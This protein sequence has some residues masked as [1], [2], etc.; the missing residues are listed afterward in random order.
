MERC[1]E[2][3]HTQTKMLSQ[4]S[5][6]VQ[7]GCLLVTAWQDTTA[8]V[9]GIAEHNGHAIVL[10]T[11]H[12]NSH[13][14]QWAEGLVWEAHNS[15]SPGAAQQQ[16]ERSPQL[17]PARSWPISQRPLTT[18][19]AACPPA[20]VWHPAAGQAAD[21]HH[22]PRPACNGDAGCCAWTGLVPLH[23]E[24]HH[25]QHGRSA[26]QTGWTFRAKCA[27]PSCQARGRA[28]CIYSTRG[29]GGP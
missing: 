29:P 22:V 6:G 20:A 14:C 26:M 5:A 11:N 24:T 18:T 27:T 25:I 9:A 21:M 15:C 28:F 1:L 17:C 23:D 19:P 7:V 2:L 3:M 16:L 12:L 4:T 13:E 8:L 10:L